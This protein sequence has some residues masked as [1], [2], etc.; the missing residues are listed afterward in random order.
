MFDADLDHEALGADR[1][2]EVWREEPEG[3]DPEGESE[4]ETVEDEMRQDYWA[5]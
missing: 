3:C 5:V 2:P 1:V 4:A